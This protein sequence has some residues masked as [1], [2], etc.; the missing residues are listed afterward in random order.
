MAYGGQPT[1]SVDGVEIPLLGFGT[2]QLEPADARRM[3]AEALRV[4]SR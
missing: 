2:W 3:V 4:G 1:L